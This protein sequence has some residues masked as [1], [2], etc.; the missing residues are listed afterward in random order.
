M[1]RWGNERVEERHRPEELRSG[2][3]HN[4]TVQDQPKSNTRTTLGVGTVVGRRELAG[5]DQVLVQSHATGESQWLPFERLIR[6]RSAANEY[7]HARTNGAERF[8]LKALAHALDWW[9]QV[10]GALD[11][12]DVDPLPHQIDLVHRI[13]ISD[14]ANWLIADDVGLGKT[15][16]VGL[17]LA[18]MKRKRR[19]KRVL[20]ICPAGMVRQWQDEM[21]LK[22]N[23]TYEIYGQDFHLQQ[24]A[25]WPLHE[26]VIVSID[27]AKS[28]KNSS[29]F[30]Q[31]GAWDVI[32][33]DEAHHL[34]KVDRQR[35]TQRFRLAEQMQALTDSFIFLTG[36]PHRGKREQFAN[37]L[38]LLR[39]DLKGRLAKMHSDPSVIAEVVLR[40]RKSRV[41]DASGNLLFRGLTTH[42]VE[43]PFSA[44]A[45]AFDHS[46]QAYIRDGYAAA[47][48]GG[49]E[50]RAVNF[51]MTTY[52]KLAASSIAAIERALK[53][54]L[55]KLTGDL[56]RSQG[57]L[58]AER[59]EELHNAFLDGE[60]GEDDLEGM[61]DQAETM[62][63]GVDPFFEYELDLLKA[64]CSEAEAVKPEDQKLAS[65]LSNI[66]DDIWHS[67][68]KLLVFTE[69]R[70]TQ[71]Y[72]VGA[73]RK[74][75]PE[76]AVCQ[77]NGS[78]NVYEKRTNIDMFNDSARFMVSTEAGGEGINLHYNCHMLVNY[79]MPWNPGRLVQR[80][81]RLYRYGQEERVVVFNLMA[82]D[83]FD[84]KALAMLL[85]KVSRIA[86]DMSGVSEEFQDGL[87]DEILGGLLERVDVARILASNRTMDTNR[88]EDEINEAIN[89]AKESNS[90]QD[91]LLSQIEGYDPNTTAATQAFGPDDALA[92]L[93]GALIHR[94]ISI[95]AKLHSDKLLEIELPNDLRGKFPEF[96][97]HAVVRITADR[98]LAARSDRNLL[99]D[100]ASPFFQS[101]IESAKAPEFGGAFATVSGPQTGTLAIYK[102]RWATDQGKPR[103]ESLVPVFL[104]HEAE[105]AEPADPELFA[106]VLLASARASNQS[107]AST[108]NRET[109]RAALEL[110]ND[111]A[112][113][114][115]EGR[116]TE[117]QQPNDMVLLATADVQGPLVGGSPPPG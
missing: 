3:K 61:V 56:D 33:F 21:Q 68:R 113:R 49:V 53:R 65:F 110:L 91:E 76:C 50:G 28:E 67:G 108:T 66:V 40:N 10:T 26:K 75:Y 117:L 37:L 9:N 85:D 79:D 107:A 101:L 86:Q 44:A 116:C 97:A 57:D 47:D 11:R 99:M 103:W 36:T 27:R 73:L 18:A 48:V 96:G 93:E 12:L 102:L 81:G 70:A 63:S 38:L 29:L 60:D 69:Y 8:R 52:R 25:H 111:C 42:R 5:R 24:L 106:A 98:K 94:G 39:P 74:R 54:R 31:S 19:A 83:G 87:E 100:F 7:E 15:I 30:A 115:L 13:M 92:F 35:V 34:N 58:D 82:R 55:A 71:D 45:E 41:T 72:L 17:L 43:V 105:S 64:L 84:N 114:E 4:Y 89:R 80:T 59:F 104:S 23:E 112:N 2:F 109:R 16:E 95:R 77:I 20:V 78:M 88:N 62:A 22:F 6:V 32:V 14:H 46:L 51:V 1:V 90:L